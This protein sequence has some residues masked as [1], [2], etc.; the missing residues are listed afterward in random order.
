MEIK[1]RNW[2]RELNEA[3]R[4]PQELAHFL[5][6]PLPP[7][8]PQPIFIPRWLAQ[9]IKD[10]GPLS[11]L[12]KQF[13][14]QKDELSFQGL[15]DPIDDRSYA[16]TPQLIHRYPNRALWMPTKVCPIQCRYC[17]RKNE[18]HENSWI[19][20]DEEKS[21]AYL[22]NHP[23]IEEII[24][25]GGD[26]LILSNSKLRQLTNRLGEIKSLHFLRIHT[27]IP[28]VLPSRIDKGLLQLLSRLS[29]RF[30]LSL[31]VHCNHSSELEGE[32]AIFLALSELSELRLHLMSQSVLLKGVNDHPE[33]L[34]SLF[35]K[36]AHLGVRPYYLH[37]PDRV[38]GAMHFY[39]D[40]EEGRRIYEATKNRLSG[41]ML[42]QYVVDLPAGSGKTFAYNSESLSFSGRLR[43]RHG[44]FVDYE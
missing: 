36:L 32:A 12:G 29:Q 39:L 20:P 6:C 44:E 18:L 23:E 16:R 19:H 2:Q 43:G 33:T 42:P 10:K 41:W 31:V 27:R 1:E 38:R 37:H 9:R 5:N 24:L 17:F 35:K 26:P 7:S 40:I 11:P 28:T 22:K 14:P 30:S 13:I 4:T 34:S 25:T 15:E 3:I 8:S 21:L